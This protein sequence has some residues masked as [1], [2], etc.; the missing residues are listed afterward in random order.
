LTPWSGATTFPPDKDKHPEGTFTTSYDGQ[1]AACPSSLP[2]DP[3]GSVSTDPTR[4][5]ASSTLSMT[6]SNPD[7][8]Q[9]LRTLRASL[10]PGL[11]GRLPGISLCSVT[12]AADGTCGPESRIGSVNAAV[13]S[14]DSP[15]SLPG[16]VYLA[17]QLEPGDPASL[18][19]VV[20]AKVGPFDF[21]NVVTRA[22]VVVRRDVG[23]DV[24][25]VEDLPRIVGGIPVRLRSVGATIDRRDFT[26][27]PTSCAQLQLGVAFTSFGGAGKNSTSPYEATG[28]GALPF[29]P[30]LRFTAEGET[31]VDGHPT[32]EAVVTQSPGEANIARSRVVLP[33][34]LRPELLALQRPGGL[35]TEAALATRMCPAG[36]KVGTATVATPLLPEPLSGPVYVV[37]TAASVLPKLTIFLDGLVSIQIDAQNEIQHVSIVNRF[38]SVPDVPFSRFGLTINGGRN[39]ILKNFRNLCGEEAKGRVTF[40]AQSGKTFSESPAIDAPACESASAAPQVSLELKGVRNGRPV[41]TLRARRSPGGPKLR[42][43]SLVLPRSLRADPSMARKGVLVEASR[44]LG[45]SHWKLTRKGVLKLVRLPKGG[46]T[47]I[48]AT[49]R[50]G[51][52]R[53]TA[54]L[55]IATGARKPKRLAFRVKITDVGKHR[56]TIRQ[57]LRPRS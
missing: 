30:K 20:P 10:P 5:G 41:L 13:G 16:A 17:K 22:R 51:V 8:H 23:L 29:A 25:L 36:S 33:D 4:G 38:D 47:S 49:L 57:R 34:L 24:A 15:L 21:G 26:L 9:L 11:V 27:N 37:Q 43:L 14:G 40:T 52:L 28:C 12:A 54:A 35:C 6:L 32:L 50:S 18:S 2:F 31:K 55:R 56:F 53:P 1:G 42:D 44:R 3:S 45:H 48:T 19:I 7:R 39:G 46:V